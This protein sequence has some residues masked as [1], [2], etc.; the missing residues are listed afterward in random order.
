MNGLLIVFWHNHIHET[1]PQSS[2]PPY[3]GFCW[4]LDNMGGSLIEISNE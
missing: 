3:E 1:Q 2:A 4:L